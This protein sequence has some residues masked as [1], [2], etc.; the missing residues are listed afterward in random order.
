MIVKLA[1]HSTKMMFMRAKR[2]P[3]GKKMFVNEDLT[4]INHKFMM[5]TKEQCP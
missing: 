4:K 1:G 5:H 3:G 2:N